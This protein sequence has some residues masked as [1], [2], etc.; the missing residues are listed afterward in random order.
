LIST[1][2]M[3]NA[4]VQTKAKDHVCRVFTLLAATN[5][6]ANFISHPS[7]WTEDLKITVVKAYCNDIGSTPVITVRSRRLYL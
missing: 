4:D 7:A 5:E 2:I 1:S 3:C 6:V